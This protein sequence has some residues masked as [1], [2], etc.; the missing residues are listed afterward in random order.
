MKTT[1]TNDEA[2]G[3][4]EQEAVDQLVDAGLLDE[5]MARV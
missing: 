5:V 4:A 1:M 3:A 2:M